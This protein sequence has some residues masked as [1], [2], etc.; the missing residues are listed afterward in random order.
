MKKFSKTKREFIVQLDGF[1]YDSG[2]FFIFQF[3]FLF[4]IIPTTEKGEIL[5]QQNITGNIGA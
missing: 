2:V 3:F 5:A 1:R 4:K